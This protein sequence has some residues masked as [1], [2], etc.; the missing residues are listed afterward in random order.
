MKKS[1]LTFALVLITIFCFSRP[2][3]LNTYLSKEKL[4]N[5]I[6]NYEIEK[7]DYN[8]N[9]NS[10]FILNGVITF[11]L[12]D[13]NYELKTDK[14]GR[15]EWET[16]MMEVNSYKL[17]ESL[18]DLYKSEGTISKDEFNDRDHHTIAVYIKKTQN[19][20]VSIDIRGQWGRNDLGN[21]LDCKLTVAY[22]HQLFY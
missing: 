12:N 16:L 8:I 1:I 17:T 19:E 4:D 18:I 7:G 6:S 15:V 20:I 9:D 10:S 2:L 21:Y 22:F 11:N 14:N 3:F 5:K 13:T